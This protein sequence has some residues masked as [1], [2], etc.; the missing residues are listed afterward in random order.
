MNYKELFL[1]L[2][3]L[4][5]TPKKA[6][7]EITTETPRRDVMGSFVYPLI[8]L[9]GLA[10]LLSTFLS[11]GLKRSV[12]QPALIEMCNY[13]ISLFGGFFLATYLTDKTTQMVLKHSSDMPTAQMFVGY[14]MGI[15]FVADILVAL[16]P[17]LFI[18]KWLL[19]TYTLYVVWEG[20]EIFFAV[21]ENQ[22]MTFTALV[23]AAIIVS[24]A[25]IGMLFNTLS[26][27][28]G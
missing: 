18:F 8:A 17:L 23:S 1:R 21:N 3:K 24:P 9:G 22:R 19:T 28:L 15:V 10:I 16:F 6:W 7:I 12:Y 25:L 26:N 11:E 14:A 2:G 13:C 27:L 5:I 20:S 4:I